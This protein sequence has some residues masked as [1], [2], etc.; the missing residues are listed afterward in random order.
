MM[1]CDIMC[2]SL[3]QQNHS[4]YRVNSLSTQ[5]K[6]F[7]VCQQYDTYLPTT[8]AHACNIAQSLFFLFYSDFS[9]GV[10]VSCVCPTLLDSVIYFVHIYDCML[11]DLLRL[12]W[13]YWPTVFYA[14]PDCWLLTLLNHMVVAQQLA[15]YD[16]R[17]NMAR[18]ISSSR[19]AKNKVCGTPYIDFVMA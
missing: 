9:H 1:W 18:G 3:R 12:R 15:V 5:E 8:S 7:S 13:F 10:G 2:L 11:E 16:T 17:Y 4:Q 6:L 14:A 19:L